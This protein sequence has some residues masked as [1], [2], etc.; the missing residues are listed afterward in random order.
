MIFGIVNLKVKREENNY[1][2]LLLNSLIKIDF[3]KLIISAKKL[4]KKIKWMIISASIWDNS[5]VLQVVCKNINQTLGS[6]I[7]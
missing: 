4:D 3:K 5:S 6:P 7:F 1:K 2:I